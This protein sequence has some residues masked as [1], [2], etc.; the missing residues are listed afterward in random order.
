MV[1]KRIK[2]ISFPSKTQFFFVIRRKQTKAE[3]IQ[4]TDLANECVKY[5]I[6]KLI[7][8]YDLFFLSLPFYYSFCTEARAKKQTSS[9][10][11]VVKKKKH[12]Q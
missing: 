7:Y 5:R 10:T 1:K 8:L 9:V 11:I 4:K 2:F 3:R 6:Y 12:E